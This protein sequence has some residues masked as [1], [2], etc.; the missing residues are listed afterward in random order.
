[1]ITF[2]LAG[3][4]ATTQASAEPAPAEV[5]AIAAATVGLVAEIEDDATHTDSSLLSMTTTGCRTRVLSEGHDWTIDWTKTELLAPE[6]TFIF[7]QA[8][9]VKFAIVGDA[10]KPDQ[11][12]KLA[13]LY[14]AMVAVASRCRPEDIL[15]PIP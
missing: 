1:M 8:P 15:P 5:D 11:A 6:A 13:A 9:P 3:L 4:L 14:T 2:V 10:S 7:V 12:Q